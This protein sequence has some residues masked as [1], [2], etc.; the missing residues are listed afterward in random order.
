MLFLFHK[1]NTSFLSKRGLF[2]LSLWFIVTAFNFTKAFHIDDTFHLLSAQHI[3]Q[4]PLHPMSG[5]VNWENN[6]SP[7]YQHNQPS[8]YFALMALVGKILGYSEMSMHILTALFTGLAL[9]FFNALLVFMGVKRQRLLLLLFAFN[10]AFIVNQN[11]MIDVPVL[12]LS[13]GFTFFLLKAG[14][15]KSFRNYFFAAF[16]LSIGV[17]LK[18]SLLPLWV[19]LVYVLLSRRHYRFL[20]VI[21]FPL[22]GLGLW[23]LWNWKEFGAFHMMNR[24][25][26]ASDIYDLINFFA[27]LGAVSPFVLSLGMWS[28]LTKTRTIFIRLAI[29]ISLI[30]IILTYF[31]SFKQSRIDAGLNILFICIGISVLFL[32]VRYF[33]HSIRKQGK[34]YFLSDSFTIGLII[35]GFSAFFILFAPF[36]ATRH[37]LLIIPFVLL[38]G[39][40]CFE[41][42]TRF[43]NQLSVISTL[44]LGF[45]LGVSD[46]VYADYYRQ[47]ARYQP[48]VHEGRVWYAGHWGWQWYAGKQGWQEFSTR[49]KKIE[50]GDIL[51]YPTDISKQWIPRNLQLEAIDSV[52]S[53]ATVFTFFSGKDFA[54]FYNNFW[55]KPPWTLSRVPIDTLMV[56]RVVQGYGLPYMMDCI[57]NDSAWFAKIKMKAS[58]RDIPVDSMLR[59]DAQWVLD[60]Q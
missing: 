18:Y 4:D 59:L 22:V 38:F 8:F 17:L 12:A 52:W 51:L 41:R 7:F 28:N 47:L 45:L 44:L 1:V 27:C 25:G 33:I 50:S 56:Y 19:V 36:I 32:L 11:V 13:L 60:K 29:A 54:S 53:E 35:A 23:S 24:S 3:A 30:G 34:T 15:T 49:S 31:M 2:L 9:Y 16:L 46:W 37:I 21:L 6:P 39:A 14:R 48:P 5:T 57:R 55:L 40:S 42:S 43:V 58:E 20:Y 10:P 26:G